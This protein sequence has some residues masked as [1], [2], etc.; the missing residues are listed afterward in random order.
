MKDI[1]AALFA[2]D[3]FYVAFASGDFAAMDALWASA[4]TITCIHPGW[5]ALTGRDDVMESWRNILGG[6]TPKIECRAPTAHVYGD[7]AVVLCY[8]YLGNGFL[9]A[10]NI[11]VRDGDG[12]KMIH[13]Q[14]APARGIAEE[15]NPEPERVQ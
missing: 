11:F 6:P 14:A 9:V 7:T 13:H 2:N 1:Q 3:A 12:W 15:D 4:A 10:T 8:E 5:N